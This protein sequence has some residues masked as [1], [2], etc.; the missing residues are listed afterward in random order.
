MVNIYNDSLI[1]KI[2]RM[3]SSPGSYTKKCFSKLRSPVQNLLTELPF[4]DDFTDPVSID[5]AICYSS[6]VNYM[7]L[8]CGDSLCVNCFRL[9]IEFYIDN[10]LVS[11]ERRVCPIC[12]SQIPMRLL[13]H[14]VGPKYMGKLKFLLRR[15]KVDKIVAEKNAIYCP[16]PDCMGFALSI[17]NADV[18]SCYKC[19]VSICALCQNR[20]HP[21]L[22]CE[23]YAVQIGEDNIND[24]MQN[25]KWKNCPYCS[26]IVEKMDGC[27]CVE[28]YSL[29]CEGSNTFCYLCGKGLTHMDDPYMHFGE[30]GS[31]SKFCNTLKGI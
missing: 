23:D 10:G 26:S 16:I 28:C 18:L 31:E 11:D 20:Y 2:E 17:E 15:R 7:T 24:L 25:R 12:S 3:E 21:L 8:P 1:D 14:V 30:W 6:S 4:S 13:K 9:T 5:C 29:V 22:S 27:N 19:R